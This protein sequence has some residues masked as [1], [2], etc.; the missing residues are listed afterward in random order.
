MIAMPAFRMRAKVLLLCLSCTLLA[1]CAQALLFQSSAA[2]ILDSRERESSRRSL[3]GM[4]DEL[5]MWIK[6]YESNLI[7]IY[8]RADFVR[9]LSDEAADPSAREGLRAKYWRAA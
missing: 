8:N 7:R 1:L 5:Y 6:S 2:S 3:E 4:Q 9:D